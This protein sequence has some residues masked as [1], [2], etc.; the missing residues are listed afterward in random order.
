M[1]DIPLHKLL[2]HFPVAFATFAFVY[3]AWAIYGRR[4]HLHAT[5]YSLGFWATLGALAAVV[6]GLQ[7]ANLG[8]IAKGVITGHALFGISAGIVLAA[9]GLWR[10]SARARGSNSEEEYNLLWLVIEGIAALLILAT[11]VTGHRLALI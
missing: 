1:F 8:Q 6:S 2:V 3:D 11:A 10:Y 5:G 9:F 7:I 4:P